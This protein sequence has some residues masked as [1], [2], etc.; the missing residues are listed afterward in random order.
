MRNREAGFWGQAWWRFLLE[1]AEVQDPMGKR[2]TQD[3][4]PEHY[5]EMSQSE[6]VRQI[7]VGSPSPPGH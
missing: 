6:E 1:M 2:D 4:G 3:K 5:E 7:R